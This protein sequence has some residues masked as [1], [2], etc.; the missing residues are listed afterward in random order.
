VHQGF[1]EEEVNQG[2][3]IVAEPQGP[4]ALQDASESQVIVAVPGVGGREGVRVGET[5]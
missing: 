5:L 1:L 4:Q 2:G 3:L